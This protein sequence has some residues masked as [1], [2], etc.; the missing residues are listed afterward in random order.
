MKAMRLWY[1]IVMNDTFSSILDQHE[2][3]DTKQARTEALV[4][5]AMQKEFANAEE[6]F[7]AAA[8]LKV[9]LQDFTSGKITDFPIIPIRQSKEFYIKKHTESQIPYFHNHDFYELIYVH[10][11]RCV[12]Y[13]QD[14]CKLCLT[15]GQCF[16]LFPNT[17]HK[18]EKCKSSD[19]I[20]KTVIP[21][22]VFGQTGG[23]ILSRL[24]EK[25]VKFEK[26]SETAKFALLKL[27]EEQ[28]HRAPFQ[29]LI[30]NSYLT[31]VFAELV[32]G[33]KSDLALE[34]SLNRYFE[35]HIKTASLSKFAALQNYNADYISRLI[36]RKT[37]KSF[38]E[39]LR[40]SRLSRAKQLLTE[41]AMTIEDIAVEVGFS[42]SSGLYKQF[43][44]MLGMKPSEYRNLL[45]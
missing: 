37:G 15:E 1:T 20:L 25:T 31:I 14:G 27:L 17:I 8:R 2:A 13:F 7:K 10:R 23:K 39:L 12:Q 22:A 11:G 3:D 35:E 5:S 38:S 45:K 24:S 19:I 34:F 16:L 44:S 41:S 33:Q 4:L 29:G 6:I 32:N 26:I 9:S 21:R 42:N 40:L 18:I 43:F 36:K 30:V 28:S